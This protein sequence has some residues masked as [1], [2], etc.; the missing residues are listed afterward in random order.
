MNSPRMTTI[1]LR[2]ISITDVL[3]MP[4]IHEFYFTDA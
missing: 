4:R 2:M 1:S 3:E